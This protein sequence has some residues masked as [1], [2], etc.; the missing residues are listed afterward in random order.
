M[1]SLGGMFSIY[2]GIHKFS[3]PEPLTKPMIAVGVLLLVGSYRTQPLAEGRVEA[4]ADMLTPAKS[5][6]K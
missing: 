6:G 5:C 2:E 4:Q 1:F 3:S